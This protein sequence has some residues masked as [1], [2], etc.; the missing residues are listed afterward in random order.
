MADIR[1]RYRWL[2]RSV[3]TAG[4]ACRQMRLRDRLH[5]SDTFVIATYGEIWVGI[6]MTIMTD[7]HSEPLLR[8]VHIRLDH[9]R[10]NR[11]SQD[12][13]YNISVI[14][15]LSIEIPR[16]EIAQVSRPLPAASGA[17][18]GRVGRGPGITGAVCV[19]S[20]VISLYV[21]VG[22]KEE[23]E[24]KREKHTPRR[25]PGQKST[26]GPGWSASRTQYRSGLGK[27]RGCCPGSK[28]CY[29]QGRAGR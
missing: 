23:G 25:Q 4:A 9:C 14:T 20:Y 15:P 18:L 1:L 17:R 7:D 19:R 24:R 29:R 5:R 3:C 21:E 12:Q 26:T 2:R 8:L 6:L 28:G 10:S 11:R 22:N 16:L 13:R 27:R